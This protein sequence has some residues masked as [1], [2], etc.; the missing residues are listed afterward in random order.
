MLPVYQRYASRRRPRL[1]SKNLTSLRLPTGLKPEEACRSVAMGGHLG[2]SRDNPVWCCRNVYYK[3]GENSANERRRQLAA[4]QRHWTG[5]HLKDG[6]CYTAS[7]TQGDEVRARTA[8]SASP[9][10]HER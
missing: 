9:K 6:T 1:R 5:S 10:K 8:V 4:G 2:L 3:I 7:V